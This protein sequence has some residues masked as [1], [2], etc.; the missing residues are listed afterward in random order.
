MKNKM[1]KFV[2]M[3]V[4]SLL[5]HVFVSLFSSLI[6]NNFIINT[7]LA[8]FTIYD[9]YAGFSMVFYYMLLSA[10]LVFNKIRGNVFVLALSAFLVIMLTQ[11]FVITVA[12]NYFRFYVKTDQNGAYSF[13]ILHRQLLRNWD[14]LL[15]EFGNWG[16]ILSFLIWVFVGLLAICYSSR[17]VKNYGNN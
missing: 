9:G 6:V 2:A 11:A 14:S 12:E 10:L 3:L 15:W 17:W 8:N 13:E 5:V 1:L 4:I 16:Q 7:K